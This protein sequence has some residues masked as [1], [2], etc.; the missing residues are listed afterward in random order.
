[1]GPVALEDLIVAFAKL[2]GIGRVTAQ[3]LALYVVKR[4]RAEAELLA[5]AL[6]GAKDQI[7]H[8]G[9]C[10]NFTQKGEELCEVCRD[11]RRDQHFLCVVAEAS[12]VLALELS[13]VHNGVYHVL[14][15][16]LSPQDGVLPEDLRIEALVDRVRERGVREV[17]LALNPSAEGDATAYYISQQL[18]PL[19]KV[20]GLARGLPVGADL[21]LADRVTLSHAFSGRSSL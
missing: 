9:T 2:P 8:C 4:P 14:G 13:Q 15:G 21:D 5:Q 12:D 20:S 19:T 10:S 17:V 3:R 18:M 6:I 11:A 7:D 1:M 16:V